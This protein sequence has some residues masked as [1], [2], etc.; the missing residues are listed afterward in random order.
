MAK[1]KTPK[2]TFKTKKES[3]R[4]RSFYGDNHYVKLD[5]HQV[6]TINDKLPHKVRFAIEDENSKKNCKWKWITLSKEH[7]SV[8]TAKIWLNEN[9]TG[10]IN[11]FKLHKFED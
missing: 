7:D 10:I 11:K 5:G 1:E 2:F 8:N 9:I 4:Y 6:G 3:G